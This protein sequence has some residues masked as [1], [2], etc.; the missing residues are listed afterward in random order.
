MAKEIQN[1]VIA[2]KWETQSGDSFE[3]L[4]TIQLAC[5]FAKSLSLR[6]TRAK[7]TSPQGMRSSVS[8]SAYNVGEVVFTKVDRAKPGAHG[9]DSNWKRFPLPNFEGE[10]EHQPWHS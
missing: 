8:N 2:L 10:Q 4:A 5:A 1:Y 7:D 9:N 6:T 3:K